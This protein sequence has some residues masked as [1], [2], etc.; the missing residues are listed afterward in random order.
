L[1]TCKLANVANASNAAN[2]AKSSA[3]GRKSGVAIFLLLFGFYSLDAS[4][5]LLL[6]I[7]DYKVTTPIISGRHFCEEP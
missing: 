5:N 4:A 3:K 2:A 1:Q 7:F 6:T